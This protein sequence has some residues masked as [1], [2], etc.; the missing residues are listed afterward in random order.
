MSVGELQNGRPHPYRV[1]TGAQPNA[2]MVSWLM[3][4]HPQQCP[5]LAAGVG[6]WVGWS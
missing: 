2:C 5:C 1:M 4:S 6:W 3:L